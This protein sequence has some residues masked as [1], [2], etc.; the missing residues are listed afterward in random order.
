MLL[1]QDSSRDQYAYLHA[2]VYRF[3]C[4]PQC[5]LGFTIADVT[6]DKTV[7]GTTSFH[8]TL[9]FDDSSSLI[10]RLNKWERVF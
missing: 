8:V 2:V 7:H 9:D 4:G 10:W 1:R 3:E 5:D 6:A